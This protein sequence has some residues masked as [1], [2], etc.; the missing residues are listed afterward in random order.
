MC[1]TVICSSEYEQSDWESTRRLFQLVRSYEEICGGFDSKGGRHSAPIEID[2]NSGE[3]RLF[4]ISS[5]SMSG[6][7]D[8]TAEIETVIDIA[9]PQ[10]PSSRLKTEAYEVV[11]A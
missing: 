6:I 10:R 7:W 9:T 2:I 5:A 3:W 8:W 1:S 4:D 11:S